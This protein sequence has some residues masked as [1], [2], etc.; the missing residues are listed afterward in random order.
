MTLLYVNVRQALDH[1]DQECNPSHLGAR[2]RGW[3][4]YSKYTLESQTDLGSRHNEKCIFVSPSSLTAYR[5]M[6]SAHECAA[7][8]GVVQLLRTKTS[9]GSGQIAPA[10]FR[11]HCTLLCTHLR[12]FRP[13]LDFVADHHPGEV[14]WL[15]DVS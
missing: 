9:I 11:T 5:S 2:C 6:G 4:F 10:Q 7:G 1:R 15:F 3:V 8:E 14:E 12:H 13:A